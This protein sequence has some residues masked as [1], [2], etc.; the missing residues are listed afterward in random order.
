MDKLQTIL[1]N[2]KTLCDYCDGIWQRV[3]ETYP[4]EIA[5][6]KGCGT[7]CELQSVSRLEAYIITAYINGIDD[8]KPL[9]GKGKRKRSGHI[10][11]FLRDKA[12]VIYEVRPIIC[13]TH[14]LILRSTDFPG[15]HHAGSCPYNFP[16]LHPRDIAPELTIDI[17]RV[18]K[19]LTNLNMAFC[20]INNIDAKDE[21]K[22][23]VPLKEL[24]LLFG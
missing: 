12:C 3:R 24:A 1:A 5:C 23:R 16:S 22:S 7:C 18:T 10:C 17:D 9:T 6:R 14:G 2:Y 20:I 15:A 21:L 8:K 19:N 4:R 13:R 11:P